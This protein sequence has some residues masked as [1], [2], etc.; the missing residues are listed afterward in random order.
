MTC[1]AVEWQEVSTPNTERAL[2]VGKPF[3]GG[4]TLAVT[5]WLGGT[6]GPGGSGSQSG[7]ITRAV[8]GSQKRGASKR[9]LHRA[10]K[11]KHSFC[12]ERTVISFSLGRVPTYFAVSQVICSLQ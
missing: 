1:S 8:W 12:C 11:G 6:V 5:D 4:Q 3:R 7:Y 2:A 10:P 9:G